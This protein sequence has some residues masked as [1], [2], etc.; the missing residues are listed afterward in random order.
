MYQ[1]WGQ[2][3]RHWFLGNNLWHLH[4]PLL[5]NIA[6]W[7]INYF[8]MRTFF[9]HREIIPELFFKDPSL[10]RSNLPHYN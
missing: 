9:S 4:F 6:F 5:G 7:G 3:R 1:F 8:V 10:F 2:E